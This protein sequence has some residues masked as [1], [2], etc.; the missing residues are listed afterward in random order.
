M[1]PNMARFGDSQHIQSPFLMAKKIP[2][3]FYVIIVILTTFVTGGAALRNK[4]NSNSL[5]RR[6]FGGARVG[7]VEAPF[8]VKITIDSENGGSTCGGTI[9]SDQIILTAA[10]CLTQNRSSEIIKATNIVIGAGSPNS[11]EQ[12]IFQ[13]I[14]VSVHPDYNPENAHNDIGLIQVSKLK[15][16]DKIK[17]AV[18]S[19]GKVS[20]DEVFYAYGWGRTSNESQ[21]PSEVMLKTT[22]RTGDT[23]TCQE[24]TKEF[25]PET[26][27]CVD[28]RLAP[29]N[30]TCSG[31]SGGPLISLD[32]LL[33]G[34]TSYGENFEDASSDI[35]GTADGGSY[36]T[37][38]SAYLDYIS[39]ATGMPLVK[40]SKKGIHTSSSDEN[41]SGLL[42][43]SIKSSSD[44][45]KNK[46]KDKDEE[47]SAPPKP[48]NSETSILFG[49]AL[50]GIAMALTFL[51]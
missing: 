38:I 1:T 18:I 21:D 24:M 12:S 3:A 16:S 27:L 7:D 26:M 11:D 43:E 8:A 2:F 34:L 48:L 13:A 29:G 47:G 30:D 5:H 40:D 37:R 14:D 42:S 51:F 36:Y 41:E 6:I 28:N 31:D 22:L 32:G 9:L 44:S 35:C 46:N 19:T 20:E 33:V 15:F 25:D 17:P 50:S 49:C 23:Q 45:D 4:A 10:H 39:E